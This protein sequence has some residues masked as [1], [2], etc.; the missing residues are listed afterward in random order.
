MKI[1]ITA[2]PFHVR[3]RTT[4][5]PYFEDEFEFGERAA[6]NTDGKPIMFQ[7][8]LLIRNG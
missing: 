7:E 3:C 8:I 2:P 1:G 6:R 5:G 4:T